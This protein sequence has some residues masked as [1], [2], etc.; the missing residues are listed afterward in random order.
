MKTNN[1]KIRFYD[2]MRESLLRLKPE[3]MEITFKRIDKQNRKGLHGCALMMPDSA[4]AP[5]FYFEDLYEAYQNGTAVDDIAQS[6]INYAVDN[7]LMTIPGGID[8]EDYESVKENLGIIV[9]GEENNRE[10]LAE[11][12]YEKIEDL[13]LMPIIF[14]N[15]SHGTGC[16]KIRKEFLSMWGVTESEI[17]EEAIENAPKLMPPTFKNLNE[18]MG[19]PSDSEND[20]GLFVVSNMYYAGGASVAF[21]P[22]FLDCIGMALDRDLF[23][24]PS[25]V[26]ELIIVT[27]N[28]Q[29][30][31]R[32]LEIV[33]E[34]NRTQVAPGD[35]LTD[36]VYHYSRNKGG[37]H[38]LL[39]AM[40]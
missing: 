10:Y 35:V 19:G 33:R 13:A 6:L 12:V 16:I 34:V 21:Y 29:D 11:M 15:D 17:I 20:E 8:I 23:I 5:T 30:P 38:K 26:N 14:T 25:S 32:L 37:F 4:A 3:E 9:I 36:A 24:L 18:I 2:S 28:G 40:A 1:T 7:N 22:G 27:D 39:P 31:D